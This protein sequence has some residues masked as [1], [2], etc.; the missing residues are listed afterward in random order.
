MEGAGQ[1]MNPT[2]AH[3]LRTIL[4]AQQNAALGTLHD[5]DPFVSVVPFA[6]MPGGKGLVI[7]VSGLSAHTKDMVQHPIV[8][9]MVMA[10]KSPDVSAQALPRATVQCESRRLETSDPAYAD[11]RKAYLGRFPEAV[12]T[13][14]LAD[15]SL[16]FLTPLSV[17]LVG[18]F[19]QAATL[20]PLN[21]AEALA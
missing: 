13:L 19:A 16:F 17:R 14:T 20:T 18:G 9:L 6:I 4:E 8:S 12:T 3:L 10:A 11:A 5:G 7:H 2:Q 15:F 1:T 21:L